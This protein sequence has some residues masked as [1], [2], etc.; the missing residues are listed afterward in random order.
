MFWFAFQS[1]VW[2]RSQLPLIHWRQAQ[3]A[4]LRVL[5][6]RAI[7][8]AIFR[9]FFFK[10]SCFFLASPRLASKILILAS[11]PTLA[12]LRL[13]LE[14]QACLNRSRSSRI[15]PEFFLNNTS[16]HSKLTM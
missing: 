6:N 9:I 8:Q 11:T 2:G 12:S 13:G 3:H 16:I 1:V 10:F 4:H 15:R 7:E 14:R 5:I